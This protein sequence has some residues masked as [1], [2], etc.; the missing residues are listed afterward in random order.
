[1]VWS[2][3]SRHFWSAPHHLLRA[4]ALKHPPTA[5]NRR[6]LNF[7]DCRRVPIIRRPYSLQEA[8]EFQRQNQK[9]MTLP[10][11]AEHLP[12]KDR[13][14]YPDWDAIA[15]IIEANVPESDWNSAWEAAARSWLDQLRKA[16]D[17]D[18]QVHETTN[19]MI[20]S[21]A[22]TSVIQDACRTYED[23]LS[24]ILTN[25]EGIASD[26]HYGKHVVLM[27]TSMDDYYDYI[28]H[29]YPDGE[30]PMS[31]GV[32]LSGGSYIHYAFPTTDHLSYRTV[33]VHEL[34][35]GCL[36]H[37]PIPT[38][39]NEALAMRMEQ[40]ICGSD[41]FKLDQELYERHAAHWNAE[42]IQQFWS[43]QSWTIPGDSFELS[44]NLAQV[45]F[46]K[47]E[48]DLKAS[49]A[50]I[51]EFIANA[52]LDDSGEGAFEAA[53]KLSLGDLVGSFLGEDS[54]AP[55]PTKWADV[56]I[57]EALNTR[58][59]FGACKHHDQ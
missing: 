50:R 59:S 37:L 56:E 31:G 48:V 18:Y 58:T 35:H 30:H 32:C 34:T 38:W 53:F 10:N 20:L 12:I 22:P 21:E 42:T 55:N 52:R 19:F 39:I 23:A 49:R 2:H 13:F 47:I 3:G 24:R 16:L 28:I 44:Y 51:F 43:G 54:W 26:E 46:R 5:A 17:G 9:M 25:L 14:C 40:V 4:H 36:G 57:P 11:I 27:F 45:L 7:T 41:I 6:R 15:G 8:H 33:L 1:M 29:F